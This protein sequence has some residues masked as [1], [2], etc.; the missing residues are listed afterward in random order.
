M[1][2]SPPK[3][4]ARREIIENGKTGK[5][6]SIENP[7]ELAEAIVE[8]LSDEKLRQ[9]LSAN[10]RRR[11]GGKIQRREN[12]CGNRKTLPQCCRNIDARQAD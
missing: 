3:P 7:F 12:G 1:R 2:S 9:N 5:L 8:L 6:V 10:A 11:G 4:T